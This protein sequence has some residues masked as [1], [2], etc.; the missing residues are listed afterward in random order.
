MG[1]RGRPDQCRPGRLLLALSCISS[2]LGVCLLFLC[3]GQ[4]RSVPATTFLS[5]AHGLPESADNAQMD[6]HPY[7]TIS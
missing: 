1:G 6:I 5:L 3:A 2:K 4:M 7:V